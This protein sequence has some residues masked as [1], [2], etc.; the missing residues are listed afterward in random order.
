MFF[1]TILFLIIPSMSKQYY[2]SIYLIDMIKYFYYTVLFSRPLKKKKYTPLFVGLYFICW[3]LLGFLFGYLRTLSENH[4]AMQ[5]SLTFSFYLFSLLLSYLCYDE[6]KTLKPFYCW[7]TG[8]AVKELVSALF[9]FVEFAMNINPRTAIPQFVENEY[10]NAIIYD[11]FHFLPGTLIYFFF[12]KKFHLTTDK[13]IT[14]NVCI[15]SAIILVDLVMTYSFIIK[16][17]QES[18]FL[19][20]CCCAQE[21]IIAIFFLIVRT[22]TLNNS[23]YRDEIRV[24]DQVLH[25][26]QKQ[27]E[28]LKENIELVNIKAH[29]IKHQLEKYQDRLTENEI[30]NITK[31]ISDYDKQIKTGNPVVDTVVYSSS[32]KC[33]KERIR[34]TALVDGQLF[35]TYPSNEIYYL[36]SNIMNNAIEAV[37]EVEDTEKRIISL[38]IKKKGE[39]I[40]IEESNYFT[41]S[42]TIVNGNIETNKEDTLHHGYGLKSIRFI[43]NQNQGSMSMHTVEN[44]FFLNIL[45]PLNPKK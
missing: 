16:R 39:N 41:G 26:E 21:I 24:M 27:Y 32:L 45:L 18:L 25:N 13:I 14:R 6:R 44:V 43:V 1:L 42:R 38:N 40:L 2:T 12:R 37:K 11:L 28:A 9:V 29:D 23:N 10:L 35:S 15:M 36:L 5:M 30:R 3:V 7:V 8:L 20:G 19:F 31:V 4:I 33:D 17:S 34:F 22:G